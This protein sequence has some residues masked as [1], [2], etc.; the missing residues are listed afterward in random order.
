[1]LY[2]KEQMEFLKTHE[3]QLYRATYQDY[4]RSTNSK[5]LDQMKEIYDS[6]ADKPYPA[7]WSC[8]HCVLDFLRHV[9]LIY[10]KTKK[11]L[12][13][14]AAKVVEAL[15]EVFNDVP[16]EKPVKTEKKNK[17]PVKKGKK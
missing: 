14:K 8:G 9:G 12:E 13:E 2:N 15:D 17:K 3:Q 1:M 4:Y 5:L 7:N 6:V 16:D 11:E 10:F